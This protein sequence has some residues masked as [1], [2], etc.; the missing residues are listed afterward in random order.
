MNRPS[1][2]SQCALLVVKSVCSISKIL[3]VWQSFT[4]VFFFLKGLLI[5]FL[6]FTLHRKYFTLELSLLPQKNID[7]SQKKMV[8]KRFLYFFLV[9]ICIWTLLTFLKRKINTCEERKRE[10]KLWIIRSG[11]SFL[12]FF[13]LFQRKKKQTTHKKNK[14]NIWEQTKAT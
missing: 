2:H 3:V 11:T 7:Q 5:F 4:S 6:N 12:F 10:R 13:S 1:P 9:K 14:S 8:R